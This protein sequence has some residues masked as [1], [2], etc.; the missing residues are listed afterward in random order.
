[1]QSTWKWKWKRNTKQKQQQKINKWIA[2]QQVAVI[3]FARRFASI[4]IVYLEQMII[5]II[6]VERECG[7]FLRTFAYIHS[8]TDWAGSGHKEDAK[9]LFYL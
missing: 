5:I 6:A 2:V 9:R 7:H 3:L 4:F 1:M 8:W